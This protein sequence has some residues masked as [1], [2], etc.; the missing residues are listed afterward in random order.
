MKNLV[1]IVVVLSVC[2]LLAQAQMSGGASQAAK[3]PTVGEALDRELATAESELVPLAEEMPEDKYGYAPSQGEF[4]GVRNFGQQLK[5]I[6]S[7]NYMLFAVVAG[8][9]PPADLGEG[10]NG[11]ESVRTKA[12]ILKYLKESFAYGHKVLKGMDDKTLTKAIKTP[13][14]SDTTPVGLATLTIGHNFNHYG[15]LVVYLRANGLVPP[16]SRR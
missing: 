3:Q 15:Q 4:K 11:P 1:R 13:W 14:G 9:K 16:A 7:A 2:A 10:E 8:E 5:H 12:E 6:A